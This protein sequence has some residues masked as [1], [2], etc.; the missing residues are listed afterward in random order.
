D[1]RSGATTARPCRRSSAGRSRCST[2]PRKTTGPRSAPS[3]SSAT[4]FSEALS[5]KEEAHRL[6]VLLLPLEEAQRPRLR[7]HHQ[8]EHPRQVEEVIVDEAV[9]PRQEKPV[10]RMRMVPSHPHLVPELLLAFARD[11]APGIV[12]ELEAR[13]RVLVMR[14]LHVARYLEIRQ[15]FPG[16]QIPDKDAPQLVVQVAL[17]PGH[18]LP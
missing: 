8:R 11:G 10:A 15:P 16:V 12:R 7:V 17:R 9:H 1:S 4:A 3:R 18:D 14:R 5:D 13:R 6:D 2:V